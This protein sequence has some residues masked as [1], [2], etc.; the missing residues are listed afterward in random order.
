MFHQ[1]ANL[2]LH[3][4]HENAPARF[5]EIAD[6]LRR[7]AL[8]DVC[9]AIENQMSNEQD[10]EGQIEVHEQVDQEVGKFP[11]TIH[12]MVE[13]TTI[14]IRLVYSRSCWSTAAAT[15]MLDLLAHILD[16]AAIKSPCIASLSSSLTSS[17]FFDPIEQILARADTL[18][19][20]LAIV[21]AS[22]D[23]VFSYKTL[24]C[25]VRRLATA[26]RRRL[27]LETIVDTIVVVLVGSSRERAIVACLA[28]LHAGAAFLP[29]DA[30]QTPIDRRRRVIST[31]QPKLLINGS[32]DD[33]STS[34]VVE[35]LGV[36]CVS[37]D[38]LW[39]DSDHEQST[40]RH[41]ASKPSDLAYVIF[42]S[43]TTGHPKA[44]QIE[45]RSLANTIDDARDFLEACQQ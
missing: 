6:I 17:S 12:L 39:N 32:S 30:V 42:T 31:V 13:Q 23:P 15:T 24:G 45:R 11:L 41:E 43:G 44:V 27:D 16:S 19:D 18:G 9:V 26:I 1:H 36:S 10:G 28:V 8:F 35:S 21:T 7:P 4:A 20:T 22:G 5:D 33:K 37:M 2:Q 34:V 3:E 38:E 40:G 14:A 25:R 29:L